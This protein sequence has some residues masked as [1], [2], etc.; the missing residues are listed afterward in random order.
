MMP[1]MVKPESGVK[2]T[3]FQT[4]SRSIERKAGSQAS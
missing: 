1:L 3:P 4:L 2:K